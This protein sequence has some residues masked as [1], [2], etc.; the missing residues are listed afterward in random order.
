MLVRQDLTELPLRLSSLME[1]RLNEPATR[2]DRVV[3]QGGAQ[4]N[5]GSRAENNQACE[6]GDRSGQRLP[7]ASQARCV[8]FVS[9][10]CGY[11][12]AWGLQSVRQL[13]WLIGLLIS[14]ELLG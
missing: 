12:S 11:A 5:P 9:P 8:Y 13:R 6:A 10:G 4:R 14:E 1:F 2:A 7:P 3:A